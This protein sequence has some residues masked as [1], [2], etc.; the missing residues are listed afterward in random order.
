[1]LESVWKKTGGLNAWEAFFS[2]DAWM[3]AFAENGIDPGFYASRELDEDEV[4]PWS[5]IDTGVDSRYLKRERAQAYRGEITPD[6][7]VC[8]SGCGARR[9]SEE[10]ACDE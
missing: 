5:V 4:L 10:G 3:E 2:F 8:C 6:C 9:L 1:M 7:R